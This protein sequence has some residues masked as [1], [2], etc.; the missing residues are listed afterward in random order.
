MKKIF[1]KF[2]KDDILNASK[3]LFLKSRGFLI[4]LV[5]CIFFAISQVCIK[6]CYILSGSEQ[7]FLRYLLT[8]ICMSIVFCMK[9]I[10]PL[11]YRKVM[12]LLVA[13]ALAG[14]LGSLCLTFGVKLLTPSDANGLFSTKIIV[15]IILA[16]IWLKE[17]L[18]ISYVFALIVMIIGVL[19]IT[20]PTFL[21]KLIYKDYS[22]LNGTI[23]NE[24]LTNRTNSTFGNSSIHN[25]S[26]LLKAIGIV[27][28]LIGA[29][30][31]G[32]VQV[33]LK[34]LS[35]EKVHFSVVLFYLSIFGIPISLVLSIILIATG[36]RKGA[37]TEIKALSRNQLLE[38]ISYAL[39][40]SALGLISQCLYNI[41]FNYEDASKASIF[42]LTELFFIFIFQY[43]I[44]S[45]APDVF[46]TTGAI[47]IVF[48]SL[49]VLI[50]KLIETNHAKKREMIAKKFQEQQH[51]NDAV[52]KLKE[53]QLQIDDELKSKEEIDD[54]LELKENQLKNNDG[55]KFKEEQ[56]SN[57]DDY[58]VKL[59]K[60]SLFKRIIFFKF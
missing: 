16:R 36:L 5:S 41:S 7:I 46:S 35:N 29:G 11:S 2:I 43:I 40:A 48:G 22:N 19:F 58:M 17:K 59:P 23:V 50:F 32:F 47:L 53:L 27:I 54:G 49:I 1:S 42:K 28:V 38:Q 24:T 9:K 34:K 8:F 31:S 13:R 60:E 30:G 20:K 37:L 52:L 44:L 56:L 33:L 15:V 45:I 14:N 6:K 55:L 51:K 25:E 10:N 4:V 57:D 3:K 21:V 12:K 18:T 39:I 26:T